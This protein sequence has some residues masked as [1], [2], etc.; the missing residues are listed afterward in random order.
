M[1]GSWA[2]NTLLSGFLRNLKQEAKQ[3]LEEAT[4][5][6]SFLSVWKEPFKTVELALLKY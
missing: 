2:V 6:L 3:Q 4:A 5:Q 1:S